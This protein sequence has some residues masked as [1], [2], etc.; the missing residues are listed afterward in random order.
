M[1]TGDSND[2][3]RVKQGGLG[4]DCLTDGEVRFLQATQD[5]I[6]RADIGNPKLRSENHD[7]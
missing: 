3:S 2:I 7:E 4:L 6:Q 1:A 5:W